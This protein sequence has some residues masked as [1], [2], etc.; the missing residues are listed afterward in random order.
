[1]QLYLRLFYYLYEYGFNCTHAFQHACAKGHLEVAQWLLQVKPDLNISADNESAF[2]T[3]CSNGHLEVAQWLLQVK[4]NIDISA[5]NEGAFRWACTYGYLH[6]AQWL[7]QVKPTINI[8]ACDK[9]AFKYAC[10]NGHLEVAKWLLQV[11]PTIDISSED[12]YAFCGTCRDGHLEVAKWLLQVKPTIDLCTADD[13][14]F[15]NACVNG[16]LH[17]AQW[18]VSLA[19]NK[20]TIWIDPRTNQ[21]TSII[22]PFSPTH[23]RKT[24]KVL[25]LNDIDECPICYNTQSNLQT[26]C[27]HQFCE[28]CL[29]KWL[30][31]QKGLSNKQS[32]PYC[33]A[34][35]SATTTTFQPII[36]VTA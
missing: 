2:R 3:A 26:P 5:Y 27:G 13:Y 28:P 12:E 25:H 20:Y 18:L 10:V 17:V 24:S 23:L 8:S 6:V 9:S 7:L 19:P 31:D 15:K 1:M 21:I 36:L 30:S 32:C 14:A 16:H 11:K 22:N 35:I 33:M 34:N 29:Q 4:P